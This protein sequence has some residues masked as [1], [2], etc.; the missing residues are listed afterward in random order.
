MIVYCF[1]LAGPR[2]QHRREERNVRSQIHH[3]L[4]R[5]GKDQPVTKCLAKVSSSNPR[6]EDRRQSVTA[7]RSE[8]SL[9][10]AFQ[11]LSI[12]DADSSRN[13]RTVPHQ[14]GRRSL[15][16]TSRGSTAIGQDLCS[17]CLKRKCTAEVRNGERNTD[18]RGCCGC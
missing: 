17:C 13:V 8:E 11:R 12:H 9:C 6:V 10:D 1:R 2:Y 4:S 16:S 3:V 5:K 15:E 14:S 18:G 7:E